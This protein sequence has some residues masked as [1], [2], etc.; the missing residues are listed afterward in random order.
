M[1]VSRY[2]LILK[3]KLCFPVV[4]LGCVLAELNR[5]LINISYSKFAIFQIKLSLPLK[6]WGLL[7]ALAGQSTLKLTL[8]K[9]D[10]GILTLKKIK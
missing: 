1:D 8:A 3:M 4:N 10:E 2:F 5:L 6:V 7:I 9:T